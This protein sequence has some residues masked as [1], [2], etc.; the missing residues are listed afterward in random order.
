METE[1]TMHVFLVRV[2]YML[3][4]PRNMLKEYTMFVINFSMFSKTKIAWGWLSVVYASTIPL[5]FTALYL[6]R[7]FHKI[8]REMKGKKIIR[9]QAN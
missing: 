4:K 5:H 2:G 9:S 7:I 3:K 1:Y 8:V 6:H